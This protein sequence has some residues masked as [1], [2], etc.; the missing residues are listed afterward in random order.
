M[1]QFKACTGQDP[2]IPTWVSGIQ[3]TFL[4]K[5]ATQK[6]SLKSGAFGS[7]HGESLFACSRDSND[8]II[9]K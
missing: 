5:K 9:T 4:S 1:R 8:N 3:E 2:Q 7:H 6:T